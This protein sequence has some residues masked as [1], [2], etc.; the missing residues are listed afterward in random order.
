L[1]NVGPFELK[2]GEDK[3]FFV[4]YIVG[5]GTTPLGGIEVAKQWSSHNQYFYD[6]NFDLTVADVE[7]DVTS[8]IDF[9]LYQNYPNPFNPTCK[10]KIQLT[11]RGQC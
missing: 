10:N 11:N 8:V 3:E 5:Q 1:L 9:Y 7:G 6:H 2:E 4:A